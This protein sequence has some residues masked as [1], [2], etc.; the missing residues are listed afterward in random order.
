MKT[1]TRFLDSW[2]PLWLQ[3]NLVACGMRGFF[4]VVDHIL[5]AYFLLNKETVRCGA[6]VCTTCTLY[7]FINTH[8]PTHTHP[9]NPSDV[10]AHEGGLTIK[11]PANGSQ[12]CRYGFF[13]HICVYNYIHI[14]IYIYII[15][16]NIYIICILYV[17]KKWTIYSPF[18]IIG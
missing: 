10:L 2:G 1:V 3:K 16:N 9:W 17:C 7:T 15:F 11:R 5:S 14:Y 4:V 8:P 13:P 12:V 6:C 18:W